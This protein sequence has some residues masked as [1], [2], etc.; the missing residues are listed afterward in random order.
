MH[1]VYRTL[2]NYYSRVTNPSFTYTFAIF[3][4]HSEVHVSA[5]YSFHDCGLK[6]ALQKMYKFNICMKVSEF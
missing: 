1:K 6:I 5:T 3:T 4:L 2:I